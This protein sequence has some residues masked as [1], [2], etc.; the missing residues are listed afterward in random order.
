MEAAD[1][2]ESLQGTL[3]MIRDTCS[4]YAAKP[5]LGLAVIKTLCKGEKN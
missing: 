1:R 4:D 5:E 3:N 2:V